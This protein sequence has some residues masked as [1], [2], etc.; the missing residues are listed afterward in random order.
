MG[1]I[2]KFNKKN[3]AV[4]FS[5][6]LLL[7]STLGS[8]TTSFADVSQNSDVQTT[9]TTKTDQTTSASTDDQTVTSTT[10]ANTPKIQANST[11]DV[12]AI[13]VAMLAELNNLRSQNN[14]NSLTEVGV[15]NNYAQERTNIF[16][17]NGTG[18][19][20]H[21]GWNSQ[22]MAPYNLTAEENIGQLPLGTL[23]ND[24]AE[25]AKTIIAEFYNEN[26]DAIPNYGHRKNMLNPYVGY[27]GFGVTIGT[28]GMIY[29]S[30]EIGNDAS[31]A[32]KSSY[33]DRNTY[34]YTSQNDYANVSQYDVADASRKTSNSS[35]DYV[36]NGN[37]YIY[38]DIRGGASTRNSYVN[39][40]DRE[41]T[42]YTNLRL[43][44]GTDWASD[45]VSIINGS[46]YLHVSNNGFVRAED[47][48]PWATFLAG[49]VI[50]A[51]NDNT[52]IYDDYGKATDRKVM[53]GSSWQTDRRSI[54]FGTNVKYYRIGTN[55]WLL[56][57]DLVSPLN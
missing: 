48:L 28:N 9:E 53:A 10:E 49:Q 21:V 41:G 20:N 42:M 30:Q 13:K 18:I 25:I 4:L 3:L 55:A 43:A 16:A 19:D 6:A 29:F 45:I 47:V 11:V 15:L 2:M 54:N 50:T 14:L 5:S 17:S 7:A 23:P 51:K 22:K 1:D 56:E 34:Y 35:A 8:A 37:K 33:T 27:V 31:Y 46:F 40:Y 44:P 24:P 39:L 38:S 52:V 26:N 12:S 57:S 36:Q 32:S